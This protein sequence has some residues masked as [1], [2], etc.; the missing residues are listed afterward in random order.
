MAKFPAFLRNRPVLVIATGHW[1]SL[2]G[3]GILVTAMVTWVFLVS[4]RMR[5]GG[6]NPYIGAAT[7]VTVP[8]VVLVGVVFTGLGLWRS[9]RRFR[10]RL[11]AGIDDRRTA[12]R[13]LAGFMVVVSLFNLALGSQV[14]YRAV[15]HME[16]RQFC[17][18]CHVMAPESAAFEPGPHAG[19]MCVD[20]HVGSG[21]MG[22]LESKLQGT[23]QLLQVLTNQ[24]HR[25]IP[26]GIASG[27]M[28][29]SSETCERCHW[30]GKRGAV[31]LKVTRTYGEDEYNEPK[32]SV[33]TMHVGGSAM[34]GIHGAHGAPGVEI[35][36]VA[37]DPDRQDIP[38]VE[39]SNSIT[40]E[41]RTYVRSDA[42]PEMYADKTPIAMECVDCHNRAA[43]AFQQPGRALDQAITLGLVH[44]KL[45]FLKKRGLE[46]LTASYETSSEAAS[47]IPSALVDYYRTEHPKTYARLT[48]DVEQ[49]GEVLAEIYARNV[50]P[51]LGVSWGTY[52]DNRGH[53]SSV[54]CFRCHEG[55]H[56]TASGE[57]ITNNCFACHR[58]SAV[59]D[60]DPVILKTLGLERPIDEM[61][62]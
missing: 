56:S 9:R 47:E 54:G 27:R 16:S 3:L 48:E 46:I 20:C 10:E 57:E 53:E 38:W 33:L 8:V 31:R 50:Y 22:L 32:T 14:T 42:K 55:E 44:S 62:K 21:P 25:P 2:L 15:H 6:E 7:I 37:T 41:T 11:A 23:R 18:S 61:R 58:A 36:F 39:Y 60:A 45:P 34:G 59:D 4:A 5:N 24:V 52:P 13:R 35:R 28:V 17:A 49:A 12:L 26:A 30:K 40:G 29:P 43:H 1:M 19:L 51:E